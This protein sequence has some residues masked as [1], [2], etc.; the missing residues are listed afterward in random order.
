M[1]KPVAMLSLLVI[2]IG[3]ADSQQNV[4]NSVP[5][6]QDQVGSTEP[7]PGEGRAFHLLHDGVDPHHGRVIGHEVD[8]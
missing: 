8:V 5:S 6:D 7:V 3:C 1:I 4:N 2:L